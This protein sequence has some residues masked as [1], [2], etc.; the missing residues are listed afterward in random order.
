[1]L[2]AVRRPLTVMVFL[3]GGPAR[4]IGGW[5][6]SATPLA[7]GAGLGERFHDSQLNKF[8]V[9]PIW[10]NLSPDGKNIGEMA[11]DMAV[12]LWGKSGSRLKTSQEAPEHSGGRPAP[13]A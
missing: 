13:G 8:D 9:T 2:S 3:R 11:I 6:T 12:G 10:G 1:M 5:A 4:R 7:P